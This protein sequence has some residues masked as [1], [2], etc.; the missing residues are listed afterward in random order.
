MLL[1]NLVFSQEVIDGPDGKKIILHPDGTWEPF[2]GEGE[3]SAFIPDSV[4]L[5]KNFAE[6]NAAQQVERQLSLE[7]IQKRVELA[8]LEGELFHLQSLSG[9][10][11]QVIYDLRSKVTN[12]KVKVAELGADLEKA[13]SWS[14]LLES[15]AYLTPGLRQRAIE[16]WQRK[17]PSTNLTDSVEGIGIINQNK[18]YATYSQAEDVMISPP[19]EPCNFIFSGQDIHLGK[20]RKDIQPEVLF[21]FTDPGLEAHFKKQDLI[22]GMVHL[23]SL[24]A[25]MQ[26]LNLEIAVASKQAQRLFGRMKEND[27]I[28]FNTIDGKEIKLLSKN[29]DGGKWDEAR[30][31]HI[32]RVQYP[33]GAKEFKLLSKSELD[34]IQVRWSNVK[35]AYEILDVDVVARQFACL[36]G[37]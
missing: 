30:Q 24:S 36:L 35:E 10:A 12:S 9:V 33:I 11:E 34:R 26:V 13:K 19:T 22:V 5:V 21:S 37:T 25:G 32:Y 3:R 17:Q 20:K 2:G 18:E 15:I 6:I 31:A 7:L 23:T 28:R 14:D 4:E 1:G 29:S 16:S 8:G 27:F